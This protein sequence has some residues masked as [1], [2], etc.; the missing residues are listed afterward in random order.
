MTDE[1]LP[2]RWL[3]KKDGVKAVITYI[4]GGSHQWIELLVGPSMR[5]VTIS[6]AGLLKRYE[7]AEDQS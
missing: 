4:G 2:K 3:R 6:R 1:E 7:P 5:R